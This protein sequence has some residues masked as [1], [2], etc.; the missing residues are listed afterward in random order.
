MDYTKYT[1]FPES[2]YLLRKHRGFATKAIHAGQ[3]PDPIHGAVNTPIYLSSTFAQKA[4]CDF[5]S[6]YDYG[7][8]G[9]PTRTAFEEC[10]AACEYG[11]HAIAFGSGCGAMTAVV[12]SIPAGSHIIVSDD[13]YGGTNRYMRRFAAEKFN[14]DVQFVDLTDLVAVKAAFKPNTSLLWAETPTNPLIKLVDIEQLVKI[15]KE[16]KPDVRK[17]NHLS[18]S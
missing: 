4:P 8:A 18:E 17:C 6:K 9:T 12:H 1:S 10:L 3:E 2:A 7:R 5:Y 11:K 16:T 14:F 15:A 13:V